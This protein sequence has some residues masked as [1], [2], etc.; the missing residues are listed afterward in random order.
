M[1]SQLLYFNCLSWLYP[2]YNK[3]MLISC[4]L[5]K[6]KK[7]WKAPSLNRDQIDELTKIVKANKGKN[8]YDIKRRNQKTDQ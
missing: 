2:F 5:D 3:I 7:I 6:G 1:T 8:I 4:K